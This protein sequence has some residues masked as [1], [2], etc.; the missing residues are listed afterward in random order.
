MLV[1]WLDTHLGENR[2]VVLIQ[3]VRE[4]PSH[5]AD[6]VSM[7]LNQLWSRGSRL[8]RVVLIGEDTL[9]VPTL[10]ARLAM[11]R[12]IRAR[13]AKQSG[14]VPVALEFQ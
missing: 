4:D 7:R 8:R 5:F 6:R 2:T 1:R 13:E 3:E 11:L 12:E 9:D 14:P 10:G